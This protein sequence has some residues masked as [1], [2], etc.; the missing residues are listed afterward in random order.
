MR[1]DSKGS[2]RRAFTLVELLVVIGIIALLIAILLPA[3]QKARDGAH[4]TACLSN[5]R[6]LGT[7]FVMY[8]NENKGCFP[9]NTSFARSGGRLSGGGPAGY[10]S[11]YGKDKV[12]NFDFVD[13]G[14]GGTDF[15]PHPEDWIY[16]QIKYAPAYRNISESAIGKYLGGNNNQDAII[17]LLRCP[18]DTEA[19][20]RQPHP[21]SDAGEGGYTFSYTLNAQMSLRKIS[22]VKRSAEKLLLI[23]ENNANDG[24]WAP[25]LPSSGPS[26][27]P[28]S[29]RHGSAAPPSGYNAN[30]GTVNGRI[31][32][33]VPAAFC[34][35]HG[36][37]IDQVM[38]TDDRRYA[39][40]K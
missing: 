23:E 4:R 11:Q 22:S 25:G 9:Y 19:V 34:D 12:V 16:W 37:L 32:I 17:K 27:D 39:W 1:H 20:N 36:E 33:N 13:P 35:G 21:S 18:T 14:S 31:G 6:Q 2:E 15:G 38:A 30:F 5:M 10:P 7:A 40:D 3:L 8:T 29:I 24:R 28:L 26:A